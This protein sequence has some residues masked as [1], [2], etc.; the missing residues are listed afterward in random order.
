MKD[1][2]IIYKAI[3]EV[4]NTDNP[5]EF[6]AHNST[7]YTIAKYVCEEIRERYSLGDSSGELDISK[8][9][10]NFFNKNNMF[11]D[12]NDLQT[13]RQINGQPVDKTWIFEDLAT[14]IIKLLINNASDWLQNHLK[15]YVRY[16]D[17][18][19]DVEEFPIDI[20]KVVFDFKK[21]MFEL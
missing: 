14:Y 11:V 20:D 5:A 12:I 17:S 8:E 7:C 3:K 1:Q 18:F 19:S 2:E 13:V 16:D 21:A 10:T 9:I 6:A 15:D 4:T